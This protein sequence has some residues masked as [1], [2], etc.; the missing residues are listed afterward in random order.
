MRRGDASSPPAASVRGGAARVEYSPGA[1]APRRLCAVAGAGHYARTKRY[2]PSWLEPR[3]LVEEKLQQLGDPAI[4]AD[5]R[6]VATGKF[7]SR[8]ADPMRRSQLGEKAAQ[9]IRQIAAI[10][11]LEESLAHPV[12]TLFR[13]VALHR[14][15]SHFSQ[16]RTARTSSSTVHVWEGREEARGSAH[17]PWDRCPRTAR[18]R[19]RCEETMDQARSSTRRTTGFQTGFSGPRSCA[20]AARRQQSWPPEVPPMVVTVSQQTCPRQSPRSKIVAEGVILPRAR[21]YLPVTCA[22]L[23]QTCR[24]RFRPSKRFATPSVRLHLLRDSR[25]IWQRCPRRPGASRS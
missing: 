16:T 23:S 25:A 12:R 24:S 21:C 6:E 20:R 8:R 4:D 3:V 22:P 15:T 10:Q 14:P 11:L 1:P 9:G 18:D 19:A 7:Q 5:A 17:T 13:S 2:R